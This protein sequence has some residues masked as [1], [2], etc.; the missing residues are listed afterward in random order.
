VAQ[1]GHLALDAAVAP[2]PLDDHSRLALGCD[3]R[4]VFTVA[5]VVTSFRKA[6]AGYRVP[7][8]LLSD[9]AAIF[10]GSYRGGG[11]GAPTRSSLPNA[12]VNDLAFGSDESYIIAATH[13]R[14]RWKIATP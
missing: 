14:G 13:G 5:D 3:A 8:S 4:T 7:A 1:A 10:T 2:C 9:N 12:S 6:A 11:Q